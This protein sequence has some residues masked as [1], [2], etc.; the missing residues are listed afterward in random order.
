MSSDFNKLED[1]I[2]TKDISKIK[3][4]N[5]IHYLYLCSKNT[6]LKDF[7]NKKKINNYLYDIN[8]SYYYENIF[9]NTGNYSS[10]SIYLIGLLIPYYYYYPRFYNLSGFVFMIG[11]ISFISL[12]YQINTLFGAFFPSASRLFL[13]MSILFYGI[14]FLLLNKLNHISLFF[15]SSIVSFVFVNY[16]YRVLLTVPS[17][18]NKYNKLNAEYKDE[19]N[20]IEYNE[21]INKVC[22]E[23]ISVLVLIYQVEKCYIVI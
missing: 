6:D 13:I 17:Q 21:N 5:L 20:Y 4:E 19:K 8:Q 12:Y 7:N 2:R 1:N 3:T 10:L 14:F 22:Y 18:G 9:T 23:I 15:I 16:L 11:L